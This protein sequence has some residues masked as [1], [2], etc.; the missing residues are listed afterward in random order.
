VEIEVVAPPNAMPTV[1]EFLGDV[2]VHTLGVPSS[3]AAL[4]GALLAGE[5]VRR[6]IAAEARPIVT[7]VAISS[8]H[9]IADASVVHA[10]ARRGARTAGFVYHLIATRRDRTARTIWSRFDETAGLALLRRSNATIFTS[11]AATEAALRARGMTPRR[12]DVGLDVSSFAHADPERAAPVVLFIA[13][14]VPKKGLLDLIRA[15]P[16]VLARVPSARLVVAGTG[17]QRESAEQLG[18]ELGVEESVDWP[19]FV[20]EGEKREL[21]ARACVFAAPSWEEGWGISVAEAMASALPVVAYRLE[22]LDEVFGDALVSVQAGDIA[23]LASEISK[24][25]VDRA[26]AVEL[27]RRGAARVARYDV[28]RIADAELAAILGSESP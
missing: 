15:W 27:G 12:T 24:L 25:L 20:T 21:L 6:A 3:G 26:R 1:R 4:G 22:T 17:P 8:S 2:P 7:D 23:G 19:G 16:A 9:F 14:L 13:R 10:A 11:N 28:A 18:F 5:Y